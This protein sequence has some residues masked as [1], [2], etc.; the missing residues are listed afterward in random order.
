MSSYDW[1]ESAI[2]NGR[3]SQWYLAEDDQGNLIVPA[4]WK[5]PK[6]VTAEHGRTPWWSGR[7][8][9]RN[10]WHRL[11]WVRSR[12]ARNIVMIETY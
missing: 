10:P 1:I 3:V 6:G 2:G 9:P 7:Y 4:P 5:R 8:N 11:F 12:L